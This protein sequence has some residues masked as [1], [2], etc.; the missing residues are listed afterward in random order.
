MAN[1]N[2][3]KGLSFTFNGVTYA[4]HIF[5]LAETPPMIL[6]YAV[7]SLDSSQYKVVGVASGQSGNV[8]IPSTYTNTEGFTYPITIVD[9]KAF[10]GNNIT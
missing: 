3:D 9:Q 1:S 10:F 4:L 6:E 8:V 7:N 2:P 5:H